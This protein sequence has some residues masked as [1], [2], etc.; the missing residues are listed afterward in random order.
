VTDLGPRRGVELVGTPTPPSDERR[1]GS[2][3]GRQCDQRH[4]RALNAVLTALLP[5]TRGPTWG[6]PRTV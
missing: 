5:P 6:P 1:A 4:M 3:V 2:Q